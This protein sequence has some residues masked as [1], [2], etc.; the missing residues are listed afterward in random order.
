MGQNGQSLSTWEEGNQSVPEADGSSINAG[1]ERHNRDR[2]ER[3][4]KRQG[5]DRPKRRNLMYERE[6]ALSSM[7]A[8]ERAE[9]RRL[10]DLRRAKEKQAAAGALPQLQIPE[11]VNLGQL[12]TLLNVRFEKFERKLKRLGFED[13]RHSHIVNAE[14][15]GL[16]AMEYGFDPVVESA[17]E[18][19]HPA[20]E[21]EDKS[22]LPSRP[23]VVTIM[24]HVDH[25]KTTIL[26]YLRKS[27]VAASEH[28]GITQHIGAFSVPLKSGKAITFLDTPGHAAFLD[29]RQRGAIVTDIV[30]LVV[31]ADDSVMPQTQEAIKHAT[32]AGVPMIVA[33]NKMDKEDARPERVKQDLARY[34]VEVEDFGGDTQAIGVSGKT[35]LGMEDLEEAIVTLSE[36]L[37]QRADPDCSVEGWVLEGS[38][39]KTGKSATVLVRKG[40]LKRG[41]IIVAGNTWARV[42]TM[43]N[44][45]GVQVDE[46]GPGMP[47]VVEGWKDQPIA[48]D[49]VL[50]AG[51]EQKANDVAE[52]RKARA[53][54]VKLAI[55]LEAQNE[56]RR[57]EQERREKERAAA[58]RAAA[59]EEVEPE[60]EDPN[61]S[62][63][64]G[65]QKVVFIVK[66]DVTGSVEAVINTIASIG[67]SEVQPHIVQSGVGEVTQNDI[68]FA[69]VAEGTIIAFNTPCEASI[70]RGAEEKGVKVIEQSIIYR[71]AD[72]VKAVMSERL[73]PAINQKV[74]G[75]AEI[76]Q[77]FNINLKARV[78]RKIAGSKVTNGSVALNSK[79]RV[80]RGKDKTVVHEGKKPT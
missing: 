77:P 79:V 11:F 40:T 9:R 6:A 42:R 72:E 55:D 38:K 66:G 76:V 46:V 51:T 17:D 49:E 3:V 53:D 65:P 30:V 67:N 29:M 26:D 31:A 64:K 60:A 35:G 7:E 5:K 52:Y 54:Q 50:Q 18:D 62:E 27:S 78:F 73:A 1:Y 57:L 75:E 39:K 63:T 22:I 41:T 12:A 24:G 20:P 21:A 43:K 33:I 28:G 23:P 48:G 37:D 44:E 10:K 13:L 71:L 61:G 34:G 70:R 74:T 80:L 58:E 8:K 15:A 4:E 47:A 32:S 19:L 14:N 59:G 56:T 45:A 69:T 25:G 16:I 2:R 68:E 36:I